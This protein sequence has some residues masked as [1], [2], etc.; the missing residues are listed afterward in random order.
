[1]WSLSSVRGS[2]LSWRGCGV[3]PCRDGCAGHGTD[4][5]GRLDRRQEDAA[6]AVERERG[7][8]D[9]R[10][11]VLLLVELERLADGRELALALDQVVALGLRHEVEHAGGGA[12]LVAVAVARP[13][14]AREVG[15][16][17][18]EPR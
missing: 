14:V 18:G 8:P 16:V 6:A 5:S 1:M 11:H 15:A 3:E 7:A 17:L 4:S 13:G 12:P 2:D 10:D 9:L